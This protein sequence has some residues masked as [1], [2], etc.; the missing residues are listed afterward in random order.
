MAEI[1]EELYVSD[2]LKNNANNFQKQGDYQKAEEALLQAKIKVLEAYNKAIP[3]SIVEGRAIWLDRGTIVNIKSQSEMAKL[4]D[5]I[6]QSGINLVYFETLNAGYT[7]YP[8]KITEQNP[9]TVGRDPLSWAII[10]AHARNIELHAWTWI[11]AEEIKGITSL[12]TNLL[13]MQDLSCQKT[14]SSL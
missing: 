3:T 12:S 9:M 4:F 2:I 14:T 10:E 8:G 11:F 1:Q 5:K 13:P 7:I 6:Q